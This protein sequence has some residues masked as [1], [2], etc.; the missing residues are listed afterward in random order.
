[1]T[2]TRFNPVDSSVRSEMSRAAWGGVSGAA[3][4][5][6]DSPTPKNLQNYNVAQD[7]SHDRQ[8]ASGTYLTQQR[9]LR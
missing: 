5:Y 3:R 7:A 9:E 8:L 1:M 4:A 2:N 6:M